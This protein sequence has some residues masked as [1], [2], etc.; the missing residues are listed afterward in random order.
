MINQSQVT[1]FKGEASKLKI[2]FE[3]CSASLTYICALAAV[4]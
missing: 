1:S 2:A 4:A 3:K